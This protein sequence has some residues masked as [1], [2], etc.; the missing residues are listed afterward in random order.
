LLLAVYFEPG[1]LAHCGFGGR[2]E[3]EDPLHGALED[4]GLGEVVG[5][6]GG[7]RGSNID[8]EVC[9]VDQLGQAIGLIQSVIR[10]LNAPS[11]D[12]VAPDLGL[13]FSR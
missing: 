12:I 1:A 10:E 4:A 9:S 3:I 6:G 11:A 13:R 2:D 8:I 5:G 7:S